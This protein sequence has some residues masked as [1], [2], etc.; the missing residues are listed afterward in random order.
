MK[1]YGLWLVPSPP[2]PAHRTPYREV[3]VCMGVW[4]SGNLAARSSELF[5]APEKRTVQKSC[6][7]KVTVFSCFFFFWERRGEG[8]TIYGGL[9]TRVPFST[10]GECSRISCQG[11]IYLSFSSPLHE[12][13]GKPKVRAAKVN[14][15]HQWPRVQIKV[16]T[17]SIKK[18][19]VQMIKIIYIKKDEKRKN[20]E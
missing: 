19:L 20:H 2:V 17:K 5:H 12:K 8:F 4:N 3:S 1:K 10:R 13:R 7:G 11:F 18:I 6:N 14:K 15:Q 9:T 16:S